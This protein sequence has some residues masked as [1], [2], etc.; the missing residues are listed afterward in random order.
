[1]KICKIW[2]IC[3]VR[4]MQNMQNMQN[5]HASKYA[6]YAKYAKYLLGHILAYFYKICKKYAEHPDGSQR[7]VRVLGIFY[8]FLQNLQ[9]MWAGYIFFRPC[10]YFANF[11]F[12]TTQGCTSMS[13]WKTSRKYGRCHVTTQ[14]CQQLHFLR[15]LRVTVATWTGA[16]EFCTRLMSLICPT[17]KLLEHIR[18]AYDALLQVLL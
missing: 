6:K 8:I 4:N 16:F 12:L 11:R 5:M 7:P 17:V 9:N 2:Q 18:C 1:M 15:R 13:M 10:T 3:N 14:G